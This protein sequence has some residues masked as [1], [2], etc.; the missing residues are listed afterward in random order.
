MTDEPHGPARATSIQWIDPA[1]RMPIKSKRRPRLGPSWLIP[2]AIFPTICG[3]QVNSTWNA[4]VTVA[5]DYLK[6]GLS[7][8]DSGASAQ[9]GFDYRHHSGFFA[10]GIV[11]GVELQFERFRQR[12]REQEIVVYA[13][14]SW[15]T[16]RSS[17][18]LSVRRYYYPDISVSYDYN[19]LGFGAVF[20]ERFFFGVTATDSILGFGNSAIDVET[21][22]AWPLP[23]GAEISGS[24]GH[25]RVS[26]RFDTSFTHWNIGISKIFKR[27]G[28]DIRY[29]ADSYGRTSPYGNPESDQWVFAGSFSWGKR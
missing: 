27:Y 22:L 20:K 23:W 26:D 14:H 18:N 11:T 13:G 17:M 28:F 16:A 7:Q 29:H 6:H 10:G 12:P 21:G 2:L 5:S 19:E 8:Q 15:E 1:S 25:Y 4:H 24:I 9:A 3:A